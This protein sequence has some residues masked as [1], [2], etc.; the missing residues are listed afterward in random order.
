MQLREKVP[1]QGEVK[2]LQEEEGERE[3]CVEMSEVWCLGQ[4]K[5]VSMPELKNKP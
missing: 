1:L 3:A 4:Q 2:P 5:S